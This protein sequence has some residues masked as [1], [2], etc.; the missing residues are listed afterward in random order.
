MPTPTGQFNLATTYL[1][2]RTDSLVD[3]LPVTP[4]FWQRLMSG[5]LGD[6]KNERLVTMVSFDASWPVAEMHPKGDEIVCLVSGRVTMV[7]ETGGREQLAELSEP[8]A[9][10]IVPKGTWHTARTSEPCRMFFITPGEGTD[11]RKIA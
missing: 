6:F 8:G 5:A 7:L 9:Y 11:H 4:E 10:V 2:L 1:K 3:P